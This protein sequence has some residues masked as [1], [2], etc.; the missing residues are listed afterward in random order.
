MLTNPAEFFLPFVS[1]KAGLALTSQLNRCRIEID[2]YFS[3]DSYRETLPL[4]CQVIQVCNAM[5]M[6][7]YAVPK[8]ISSQSM[9]QSLFER[10]H[11]H[12]SQA[13]SFTSDQKVCALSNLDKLKEVNECANLS[14]ENT[15]EISSYVNR[16][17]SH[18]LLLL[19]ADKIVNISSNPTEWAWKL[20]RLSKLASV[21]DSFPFLNVLSRRCNT[22]VDR[23]DDHLCRETERITALVQSSLKGLA[24]VH[25]ILI[26]IDIFSKKVILFNST[27]PTKYFF[28]EKINVFRNKTR[29]CLTK[30]SDDLNVLTDKIKDATATKKYLLL[31]H[32]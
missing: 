29:S 23:I 1:E 6:V 20:V 32:T 24:D 14:R 2:N 25:Q 4:I 21:A 18:V 27:V 26:D 13:F 31:R 8:A 3:N 11:F 28:H 19:E 22:S 5:Q 10:S 7:E 17:E 9:L 30:L 12:L 15:S 16:V